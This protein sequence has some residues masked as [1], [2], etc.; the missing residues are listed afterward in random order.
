[1]RTA[2][3]SETDSHRLPEG[4]AQRINVLQKAFVLLVEPVFEKEFHEGSY[5]YRP[6]RTCHDAIRAVDRAVN[7]GHHWVIE[8]DIKGYFDSIKHQ[9]LR[10]MFSRR[11]KDGV[12]NRLVLGWLKAGVLKEG[13]WQE[14]D[15]G[16][17]QGGIGCF[18]PPH[19][20]HPFGA[21]CGWLPRPSVRRCWPTSTSTTCSTNGL[22][23]S[24]NLGWKAAPSSFATRMTPCCVLPERRTRGEFTPY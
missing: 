15:E 13:Q 5:G 12:L 1:M 23:M 8:L 21:A 4:G 7:G 6:K 18:E 2:E 11:I 3:R 10:E 24:Q 20:S 22:R 9:E 14:S 16:T 17:P 19:G